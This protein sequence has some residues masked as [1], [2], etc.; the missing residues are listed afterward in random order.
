[1]YV[2]Y[3]H[4]HVLY[5]RNVHSQCCEWSNVVCWCHFRLALSLS[6]VS[7]GVCV[8]VTV[9]TCTYVCMYVPQLQS[10]LTVVEER[11]AMSKANE[12][13]VTAKLAAAEAEV[14]DHI[15]LDVLLS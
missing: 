3:L 11:L 13:A 5:V 14:S 1:M 7:L 15:A 10:R 12:A 2:H 4:V 9:C 8:H 6:A